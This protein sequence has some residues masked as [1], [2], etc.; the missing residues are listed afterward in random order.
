MS[1]LPVYVRYEYNSEQRAFR[2]LDEH[3]TVIATVRVRPHF[4]NLDGEH[5]LSPTE[6]LEIFTA[7]DIYWELVLRRAAGEKRPEDNQESKREAVSA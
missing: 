5:I 6:T 2:V 1:A 7:D 4:I 3:G